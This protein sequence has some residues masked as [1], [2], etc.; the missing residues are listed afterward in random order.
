[1]RNRIEISHRVDAT[2]IERFSDPLGEG[3]RIH[4]A[5]TRW[6]VDRDAGWEVVAVDGAVVRR[7]VEWD[8]ETRPTGVD[9]DASVVVEIINT[10]IEVSDGWPT[11]DRALIEREASAPHVLG[12]TPLVW[13]RV[14]VPGEQ[15]TWHR[16]VWVQGEIE[17][18]VYVD[19]CCECDR[20][21][22]NS[23]G[24]RAA[25]SRL[26]ALTMRPTPEQLEQ[27]SQVLVDLLDRAHKREWIGQLRAGDLWG[28]NLHFETVCDIT[29]WN[30]GETANH[31]YKARDEGVIG[32]NGWV[33]TRP[34]TPRTVSGGPLMAWDSTETRDPDG[35]VV[36]WSRMDD[37]FQVEVVHTTTEN[38]YSGRLTVY[39]KTTGEVLHTADVEITAGAPFGPDVADVA[40]W[41]ELAIAAV[42]QTEGR[43]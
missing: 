26:R 22:G 1:M 24:Y 38:A 30:M 16:C 39:E 18:G 17:Q 41:Q 35:W 7:L 37:R 19:Y 3:V 34:R 4:A 11:A 29:G 23:C 28:S 5:C 15:D 8:D 6:K 14:R 31:A 33:L 32:L 25:A 9:V 20:E 10:P 42:D 36:W 27:P 13:A 40:A 2:S 43:E 21:H 12:V